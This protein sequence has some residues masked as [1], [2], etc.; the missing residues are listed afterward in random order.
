VRRISRRAGQVSGFDHSAEML[1][2]ATRR[3][4]TAIAQG[5]VHLQR[6]SAAALPFPGA[7]FDKAYSINVAQF[8]PA[9]RGKLPG[10]PA[11]AQARRT[12]RDRRAAAQSGRH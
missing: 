5:R 3:N 6:A 1:R 11:R 4:R 12:L 7:T 8:F 2:M 9:P 10:I